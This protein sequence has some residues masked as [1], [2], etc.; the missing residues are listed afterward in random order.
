[1]AAGLLG[2]AWRNVQPNILACLFLPRLSGLRRGGNAK[3]GCRRKQRE[4]YYESA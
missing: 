4:I 1:M 3:A 2:G